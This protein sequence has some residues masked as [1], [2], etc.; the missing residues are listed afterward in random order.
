MLTQ[1]HIKHTPKYRRDTFYLLI[2]KFRSKREALSSFHPSDIS[3]V[4]SLI[5]HIA[6]IKVRISIE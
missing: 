4:I 2:D 1:E 6:H 5:S 3:I